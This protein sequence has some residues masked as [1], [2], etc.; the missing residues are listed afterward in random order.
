MVSCVLVPFHLQASILHKHNDFQI[1]DNIE[2]AKCKLL[3]I[4]NSYSPIAPLNL[5]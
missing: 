2:T 3:V 5:P 4:L 1:A